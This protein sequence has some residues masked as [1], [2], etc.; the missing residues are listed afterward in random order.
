[1]LSEPNWSAGGEA[2]PTGA[3]GSEDLAQ[4]DAAVVGRNALVPIGAESFFLQALDGTLG[5]VAVL[6]AAS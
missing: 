5:Q 3:E 4:G 2:G 6:K 1:M